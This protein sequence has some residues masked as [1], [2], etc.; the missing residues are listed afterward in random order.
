MKVAKIVLATLAALGVS[1]AAQAVEFKPTGPWAADY[2][3]D[4]CLLGRVFSNGK[5]D[6]TLTLERTQPG[7]FFRLILIGDA[8]KPFRGATT[9]GYTIGS[10]AQREGFMT[11]TKTGDGKQYL[12]LGPASITPLAMPA[13][14]QPPVFKPYKQ[15]EEKAEAKPV[16]VIELN[17]GLREPIQLQTGSLEAPIGALQACV[18]DLVGQWGVDAKAHE[19]LS[20]PAM[21]AGPVFEWVPNGAIPFTEFGKLVG[22]LNAIRVMVGADGKPT[23]CVADR[24]SLSDT[25]NKA[26]CDGIMSKGNFT[27]A[28][29]A[30]S[31][32]IASY[33]I[34]EMFGLMPPMGGGRR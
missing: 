24:A 11:R 9:L 33:W 30:N 3:K 23:S 4:Y 8:I 20:R 29:D 18:N 15:A 32:P 28:L 14:G 6:I 31:Q 17:K 34:T 16:T 10:T 2:G 13:P 22:G 7:Q 5:E 21:P 12:D 19:T 25:V 1:T 27:P 26:V